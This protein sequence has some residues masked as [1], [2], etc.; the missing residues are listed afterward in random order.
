[1]QEEA[2]ALARESSLVC[3]ENAKLRAQLAELQAAR[4][5][6]SNAFRTTI[7]SQPTSHDLAQADAALAES[8]AEQARL[9]EALALARDTI[10]SLQG[11][12]AAQEVEQV[13]RAAEAS[14]KHSEAERELRAER[15]AGRGE[16]RRSGRARAEC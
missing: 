9:E 2:Q 3:R 8:K 6:D 5:E 16:E 11:R 15:R 4:E 1:M 12:L 7:A 10:T 13:A 14:I